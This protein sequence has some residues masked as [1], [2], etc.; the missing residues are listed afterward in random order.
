MNYD[1]ISPEMRRRIREKLAETLGIDV[2]KVPHDFESGEFNRLGM[3]SLDLVEIVM[4][5]EEELDSGG[6]DDT[7]MPPFAPA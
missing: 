5:I 6:D 2:D 7:P 4:E 3:D 1:D